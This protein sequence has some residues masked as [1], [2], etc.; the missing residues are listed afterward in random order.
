MKSSQNDSQ[1]KFLSKKLIASPSVSNNQ[2]LLRSRPPSPLKKER[3]SRQTIWISAKTSKLLFSIEETKASR[4]TS[5]VFRN[6]N[7][8]IE[9]NVYTFSTIILHSN[10]H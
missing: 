9:Q 2:P 10:Y 6:I 4:F 8:F 5:A 3:K 7:D 1:V